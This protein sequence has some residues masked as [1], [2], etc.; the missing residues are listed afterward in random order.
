MQNITYDVRIYKTEVYKGK[1]VTTYTVR[2][3]VGPRAWKEPFRNKAQAESFLAELRSATKKGEAFNLKTGRPVSWQRTEGDMTWY[4]FACVFVDMKWKTASAKYRHDIAYAL[5]KATP[6]LLATDRGKPNDALLRK[7]LFRWG[8]NAKQRDSAPEDIAQAL[9]WVA[10]NT[11]SVSALAEPERA[12]KV[13]DAA[14]TRLDG[15]R[16]AASVARRN[17]M[18]LANAMDYAVAE[19]KLLAS[20]PIRALKWTAP[21]TSSEIDRRSVVNPDQARALLKAVKAREPSGPRLVAF[22]A[23]MYYSALR[24]EE[25]IS[26]VRDNVTLPDQIWDEEAGKWAESGDGWGELHFRQPTPDAGR[27][28]T[29]DGSHREQ[30]R[31]LKHRAEGQERRVPCPPELTV[32]L[33]THLQEHVGEATDARLFVGVR[34]GDL[35]A[36]TY[37]RAWREARREVLSA[38]QYASP[39]ARRPYDLRHACVSTWLNGGVPATQVAKWAGHGVD[40]LLRIYASCLEGQDEIAKRRITEALRNAG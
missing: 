24:P 26:L 34:G 38:Q 35:P 1:R 32:I 36:I 33:R 23:I 37:R 2:W 40:V 30:R 4:D 16:S 31:Q 9:A 29:D 39:L 13:L 7:A 6:A 19:R 20:N 5:T 28:W 10:A 27:E 8:F 14:T 18:I 12:R 15:K 25:A 21:Q 11:V 3:K 17:R 22:F